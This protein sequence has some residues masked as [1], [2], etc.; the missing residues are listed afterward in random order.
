MDDL[1]QLLPY[2]FTILVIAIIPL[3]II[4]SAWRFHGIKRCMQHQAEKRNGTVAGSIFLSMLKFSYQDLQVLVSS[5]PGNKYRHAKTEVT[6]TLFKPV[7]GSITIYRETAASKFGKALGAKDVQIGVD[8][9]DRGFMI[10]ADDELYVRTLLDF[11]L[12]N[13]LL[14]M[15]HE[16][17]TV[18]M[19]GTWL[20]VSVPRVI[21]TDE[22]YDH[23]ID[24]ACALVDRLKALP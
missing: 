2:V 10:K 6:V 12:Q 3:A 19:T 24:L 15:R 17:P 21:T 7:P 1:Q 16:K 20:N 18:S 8:D 23:L 9:F 11:T 13:K 4:L 22:E 14:E 5:L